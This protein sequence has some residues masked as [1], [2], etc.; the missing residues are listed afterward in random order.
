MTITTM[1]KTTLSKYCGSEVINDPEKSVFWPSSEM[2]DLPI[3]RR[4]TE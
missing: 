3:M 2:F 4:L 1:P